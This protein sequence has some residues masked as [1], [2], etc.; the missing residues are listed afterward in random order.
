MKLKIIETVKTIVRC[1]ILLWKV[2]FFYFIV[3]LIGKIISPVNVVILS[4][5]LKEIF[6]FFVEIQPGKIRNIF[7]YIVLYSLFRIINT[8]F[9][10]VIEYTSDMEGEKLEKYIKNMVI[11]TGTQSDIEAFDN[12]EYHNKMLYM[13][14]NYHVIITVAWQAIDCLAGLIS[15]ITI[16]TIM[17]RYDWVS[18]ILIVIACVPSGVM[19]K[20]YTKMLYDFNLEQLNNSRRKEYFIE[21]ATNRQF[22]QDV[23]LYNMSCMLIQKYN[24]LWN[25]IFSKRKRI[26]KKQTIIEVT[27]LCI[28]EIIFLCTMLNVGKRIIQGIL[29]IG[30]YSLYIGLLSQLWENIIMVILSVT[31]IW[32]NK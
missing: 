31:A 22:T 21:I 1:F 32:E 18:A 15:F 26:L 5:L 24:L 8:A 30:D 6:N 4:L 13:K 28:P 20:K 29:S 11:V 14:S 17:F 27:M 9:T 25:D 19:R 12:V 23:R 16:F 7:I 2:D 3:R 10:S